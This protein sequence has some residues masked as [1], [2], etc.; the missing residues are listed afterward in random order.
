[1]LMAKGGKDSHRAH[2]GMEMPSVAAAV[3]DALLRKVD[4]ARYDAA[5]EGE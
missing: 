5:M 2:R 1:M 4:K 3:R